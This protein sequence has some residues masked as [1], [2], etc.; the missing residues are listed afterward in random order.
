MYF[1]KC[2]VP[3]L[4]MKGDIGIYKTVWAFFILLQ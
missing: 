1:T 4:E 3:D 2:D